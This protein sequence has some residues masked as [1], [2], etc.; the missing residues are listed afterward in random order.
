[1]RA[2]GPFLAL[3]GGALA[4]RLVCFGGLLGWDDVEYWEA[5]RAL[6]AGEYVPG[7]SFQLRYTLTVPMAV[8]QAWLGEREWV[9]ALVPLGYSIAH[10]VLAWAL[11]L[12]WGGVPAAAATVALLGIV[13]LDVIAATDVHA[14]L[15]LAVFLAA[16]VYAVLRSER[17]PGARAAWLLTAGAA[18]GLAVITK[19]VALALLPA[20]GLRL[21]LVKRWRSAPAHGWLVLGLLAVSAAEM[22]WLGVVTGD[23]L[24]RFRGPIAGF[25]AATVLPTAPGFGWMLSFPG[26]L[27]DPSSG[28]FGYFAGVFYLVVAATAWALWRR[29][30]APLELALW[31]GVLLALLNFAPLD[32]SFTRPLFVHF[33][34]TL[35]PLL[36][37]FALAAALWLL[38]GLA[39]R[40]WLRGG[41][42]VGLGALAAVGIAT[43]HADH[44]A[45]T[46]VARQAVPVVARL[47][48]DARVVTDP[49]TAAQLGFL[50]PAWRERIVAGG[51]GP[52]VPGGAAIFV[53]S[54]PW[55]LALAARRGGAPAEIAAPRAS[56]E[57][58]AH[59]P[60]RPRAGVRSALYRW[61]GR[62][63]ATGDEMTGAVLWRVT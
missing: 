60:R 37:P 56:W 16:A 17:A 44:R 9:L 39:G 3:I 48:A 5:A 46:A 20:L 2:P 51:R 10:L 27:L 31:W 63:A 58:V 35:H 15:P 34:R 6:R 62:E 18:L 12:R 52:L 23:P 59:F 33:A 47:P 21:W 45:W 26:M 53:L 55:H 7:S 19:E 42:A 50:L 36:I 1:M 22:T 11:G 54:D 8:A 57:R 38:A 61:L 14:D 4:L 32:A 41:V 13:P 24:Y 29:E 43:T 25:H 30:S 28:S 40:P 49:L